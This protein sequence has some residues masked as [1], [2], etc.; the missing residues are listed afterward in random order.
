MKYTYW[1]IIFAVS[2]TGFMNGTPAA[3]AVPTSEADYGIGLGGDRAK[4]K[5][6]QVMQKDGKTSAS[7]NVFAD[8]ERGWHERSANRIT[9]H[10][11]RGKVA[12]SLRGVGPSGG[13]FS[14][15]QSFYL[16]KDLF[17]Y[18]ITKKFKFIQYSNINSGKKIYAVAERHYQRRRDGR[19]FKDKVYVSLQLENGRWVISEIKSIH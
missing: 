16:F 9:R 8:V 5:P 19:L 7:K 3:A 4:Q 13:H 2:I 11:G 14:R 1:I 15:D 6:P 17:K 12:I 10:F 18:T